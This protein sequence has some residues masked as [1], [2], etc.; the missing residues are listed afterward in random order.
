M[1]QKNTSNNLRLLFL[2]INKSKWLKISQRGWAK[3]TFL[4]KIFI[5]L[6]LDIFGSSSATR[7]DIRCGESIRRI[8]YLSFMGYIKFTLRIDE[9]IHIGDVFPC[10]YAVYVRWNFYFGEVTSMEH[11]NF[12]RCEWVYFRMPHVVTNKTATLLQKRF[13]AS[14]FARNQT[15]L[16]RFLESKGTSIDSEC[17]PCVINHPSKVDFDDLNRNFDM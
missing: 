11:M 5:R 16:R 8:C 17:T 7:N 2:T 6:M 13:Q 14:F 15:S 4:F 3:I 1:N 12:T 9:M 10:C